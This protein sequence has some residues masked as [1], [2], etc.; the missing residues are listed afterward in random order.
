MGR[1]HR[2]GKAFL[3]FILELGGAVQTLL[4]PRAKFVVAIR[5]RGLGAYCWLASGS[6]AAEGSGGQAAYQVEIMEWIANEHSRVPHCVRFDQRQPA[7]R[8][9]SGPLRPYVPCKDHPNGEE[10][11]VQHNAELAIL[12]SAGNFGGHCL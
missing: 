7:P 12:A 6:G 11:A 1:Q 9:L 10:T 3:L 8:R 2:N 5:F 4:I